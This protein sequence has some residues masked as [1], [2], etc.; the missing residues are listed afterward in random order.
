MREKKSLQCARER[1]TAAPSSL[2]ITFLFMLT[3][4]VK[5]LGAV[6]FPRGGA[7]V[8]WSG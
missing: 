3:V 5:E 6:A 1:S 2:N 8:V 7:A 4:K